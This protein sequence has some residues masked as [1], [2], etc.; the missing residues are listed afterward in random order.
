MLTKL[1][2]IEMH[3]GSRNFA[4]L[5]ETVFFDELLN[6]TSKLA[7]AQITNFITDSVTEVWLDFEF[8]EQEFSIN[9]Q[10]GGYWFFVKNFHCPDEI[11]FEVFEHFRHL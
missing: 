3:D 8:I 4:A 10:F 6:Y 2:K 11:L 9:N 7:G 1:L 5:P